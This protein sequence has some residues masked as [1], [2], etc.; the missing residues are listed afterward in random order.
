MLICL[1]GTTADDCYKL[2]YM[3]SDFFRIL[4]DVCL[5]YFGGDVLQTAA[6]A[7]GFEVFSEAAAAAEENGS[8]C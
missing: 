5:H 6:C 2:D 8:I 4:Q 3:K 1:K 7:Y